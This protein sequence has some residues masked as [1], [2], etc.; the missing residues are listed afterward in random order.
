[1]GQK[2]FQE[3]TPEL[4]RKLNTSVIRVM[5]VQQIKPNDNKSSIYYIFERLNT[6]GTRLSSQEIR[7]VVY[8]GLFNNGL[9]ELNKDPNWRILIG[10]PNEDKRQK[11]VELV[12]R[13]FR[14]LLSR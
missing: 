3:L 5:N 7:N 10:K 12:L 8:G 13:F 14:W 11:D 4:Q 1:L 6:G 2:T 9:K